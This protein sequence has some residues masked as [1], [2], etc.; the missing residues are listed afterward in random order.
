MVA[1]VGLGLIMFRLFVVESPVIIMAVSKDVV[2]FLPGSSVNSGKLRMNGPGFPAFH[3]FSALLTS[4]LF[5]SIVIHSLAILF[6]RLNKVI[7]VL[8]LFIVFASPFVVPNGG[9]VIP[10]D[11]FVK[12][13]V[14]VGLN[15]T[16]STT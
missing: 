13:V 2:N 8:F 15:D 3:I 5:P 14:V 7:H 4:A 11:W 9:N 1:H 16:L 12:V 10:H 6:V